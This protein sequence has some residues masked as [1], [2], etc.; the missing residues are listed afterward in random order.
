MSA[1]IEKFVKQLADSGVIAAGKLENFVPPKAQPKDAEELIRELVK[2]SHLTKFQ[3]QQILAGKAKAL[4]LGNYTILDKIGAGGMGQVFKAEHRRMERQVAIKMLPPA[5]VKDLAALARFQREVKAAAK[6][7]HGNIVA[8]FDADEANGVH[9]MVMEY[10][11]GRDLSATVK[12]SGPLSVGKAVTYIAQAAR[13]L[14]YAHKKGVV[15]RDIK[16]ANLLLDHE[17]T[18]K[19]LDMGLARI[20]GDGPAQAELTGTGAVMGTVDYM[21]PEQALST[22]H[23]DARADIYSLGC[24]LYYLLTGSPV[25]DGET[26]TAKLIAHQS[27]PIPSLQRSDVEIP[28]QLRA[29]F[30]RMVA[31]RID[32][33][34]QTMTEVLVD[35]E[36]CQAGLSASSSSLAG[37]SRSVQTD[38]PSDLSLA[39]G[40]QKLRAIDAPSDFHI[41]TRA[42]STPKKRVEATGDRRGV[43]PPWRNRKNLIAAS[44]V[45]FLALVVTGVLLVFRDK[46]AEKL[47]TVASPGVKPAAA[48]TVPTSGNPP[49]MAI[50]PFDE[51]QARAHQE[52]WAKHL[53]TPV[54]TTN[55]IG[56]RMVIIPPGQFRIGST[57][58][59]VQAAFQMSLLD[60]NERTSAKA[61]GDKEQ[62]QRVIVLA[63]P[64]WMSAT[65]VTIGQFRKFVEATGYVTEA[66]RYGF[67]G[68]GNTVLDDNVK[69]DDRGVSWKNASKQLTDDMPVAQVTY[70]D[71]L[72]FCDWLTKRESKAGAS[73]V[74]LPTEAEWE[75]ACR[76]GTTTLFSFGDASAIMADYAWYKSNA[77]N[78]SHPV[79]T[80]RANAFGL[81]DMHGNVD[82][83]CRDFYSSKAYGESSSTNPI[84]PSSGNVRVMRGGDW[85]YTAYRMRSAYRTG[86]APTYRANSLG[87]RVVHAFEDPQSAPALA[88]NTEPSRHPLQSSPKND[89]TNDV[90]MLGDGN[91]A[92]WDQA[93]WNKVFPS[94]GMVK[95]ALAGLKVT[96]TL[97]ELGRQS[98]TSMRPRVV[99]LHVGNNDALKPGPIE[100]FALEY[101]KIVQYLRS[102]FPRSAIVLASIVPSDDKPDTVAARPLINAEISKLADGSQVYFV[103]LEPVFFDQGARR[104]D[105]VMNNITSPGYERWGEAMKP[106]L[107][108]LLANSHN[109]PAASAPV[110][111]SQTEILTSPD[112]VWSE[113]ENLGPQVNSL[114]TDNGPAISGDGLTLVFSSNRAP[115][116]GAMDLWMCRRASLDD[117][118]GEPVNMSVVNSTDVD[119]TP[120]LSADGLRLMFSTIREGVNQ[121]LWS[122]TRPSA[123]EPFGPPDAIGPP[124]NTLSSEAGAALTGDGLTLVFSGNT[125]GGIEL[126]QSRRADVNSPFGKRENL[127]VNVNSSI[128]DRGPCLSADGRVLFFSRFAEVT[129]AAGKKTRAVGAGKILV[130]V[131]SSVDAPFD[132]AQDLGQP[133]N[134]QGSEDD[135]P[136]VTADGKLLFFSSTRPGG[137]GQS[138]LWFSRRV[139][140]PK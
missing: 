125:S 122:A 34:Y 18:V 97:A 69:Q 51:K 45:A 58:E 109:V 112:W 107:T 62:P 15:H 21:A 138:D 114:V 35:L 110:A 52:A 2:Q 12:K 140:K 85:Y 46:P 55:S 117:P 92:R 31:K 81:Y 19:I 80:K 137:Q 111:S 30:E 72:A 100:D 119:T 128:H 49:V 86:T 134:L 68:S 84:G 96:T 33:R 89:F 44:S 77:G 76:A 3:A 123:T 90:L 16:P 14:E 101:A 13:G 1:G 60:K 56:M 131:R 59:Q 38:A 71:V 130:A 36:S 50:A 42:P 27:H 106:L 7:S 93:S 29:I 129:D 41:E 54:E 104:R 136:S 88:A 37:T 98:I 47:A 91:I 87:L 113:P 99:V 65:E 9:F 105:L 4:I 64:F 53:G 40:N 73:V 23:A 75:Y 11:E 6:L 28:D 17:G 8:T 26:I 103:D 133:I 61:I 95:R 74:R 25:Y 135:F 24:S 102:V 108:R 57:D 22:K 32:D 67:G 82:E 66:E 70:A 63:R 79:A 116:V 132:L 126:F 139:P 78:A 118:F 10:V 121:D 43:S 94:V 20:E 48:S 39:L 124:V 120:W 5:M 115:R 83:W 127:G